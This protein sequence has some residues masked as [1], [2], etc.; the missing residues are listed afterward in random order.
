MG[1]MARRSVE[2]AQYRHLYKDQR[3]CGPHGIR[4]QAFLRDGYTCQRCQCIVVMRDRHHPSA[5]VAHHKVKHRGDPKLFFDLSN[6]ETVCKSDHDKLIQKEEARGYV[7]GSG[8]DGRPVDP[9]H[10]WNR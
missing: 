9:L 8:I 10:P 2:A 7:I 4:R 6:V 3:W 1:A 5:A